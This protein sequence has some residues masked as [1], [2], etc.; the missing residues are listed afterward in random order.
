MITKIGTDSYNGQEYDVYMLVA[1]ATSDAEVKTT[2]NGKTFAKVNVAA[3]KNPD[4]TTM[5]VNIMGWRG[6]TATVGSIKKGQA[7]MAIGKL[8]K[9]E[10]NGKTYWNLTAEFVA[11]AG[12]F[13]SGS[14]KPVAK[15]NTFT[16]IPDV[17]EEL[18]F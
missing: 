7:I 13:F 3:K 14:F 6:L 5:F 4:S 1:N 17:G 11:S 15:A 12:G 9:N 16:E 10:Y 2:G 18:P 8:E